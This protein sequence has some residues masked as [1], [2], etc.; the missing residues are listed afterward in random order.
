MEF[1]A[2]FHSHLIK[3]ALNAIGS[4]LT[5]P[6]LKMAKKCLFV[7]IIDLLNGKSSNQYFELVNSARK[8]QRAQRQRKRIARKRKRAAKRER[9]R[10]EHSLKVLTRSSSVKCETCGRNFTSHKTLSRHAC[11]TK[12]TTKA[13]ESK[14]HKDPQHE[15]SDISA[16]HS[17][18]VPEPPPH[19]W[20]SSSKQTSKIKPPVN[21]ESEGLML[22][23]PQFDDRSRQGP[24]MFDL[25][26]VDLS[27]CSLGSPCPDPVTHVH[28][29]AGRLFPTCTGHAIPR[30][31]KLPIRH[32]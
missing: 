12:M 4:S 1:E 6:S 14:E 24:D 19:P 7:F 5:P 15:P 13:K 11:V 23:V 28:R 17:A 29:G 25:R 18:E 3:T 9:D 2:G 26:Q 27:R 31:V 8:E 10:E 20:P 21:A 16:V 22:R 30:S 32:I